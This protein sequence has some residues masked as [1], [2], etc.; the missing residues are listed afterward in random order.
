MK[1]SFRPAQPR[2][3]RIYL[4][5]A[6]PLTIAMI[7]YAIAIDQPYRL[8]PPFVILLLIA[9]QR[10]QRFEVSD[11]SVK[12]FGIGPT[13]RVPIDAITEVYR[14]DDEV[15]VNYLRHTAVTSQR[16]RPDDPEGFIQAIREA[17]MAKSISPAAVPQP[18]L[19]HRGYR[20]PLGTRVI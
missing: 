5:I 16:F 20:P 19:F 6:I 11:M 10:Q 7:A 12:T 13:R 1:R 8:G 15:Q 17:M 2:G 18:P 4:W 3:Y 14:D 9:V